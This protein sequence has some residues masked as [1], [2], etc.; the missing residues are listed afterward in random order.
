VQALGI[1]VQIALSSGVEELPEESLYDQRTNWG[2]I[3]A[4]FGP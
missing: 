1:G 3:K 2:R 4:L